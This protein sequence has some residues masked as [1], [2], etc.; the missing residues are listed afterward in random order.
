[1][2]NYIVAFSSVILL[3]GCNPPSNDDQPIDLT[4]VPEIQLE[5]KTS[6]SHINISYIKVISQIYKSIYF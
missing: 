5:L 6:L 2:R 1:M 4:K 3:I